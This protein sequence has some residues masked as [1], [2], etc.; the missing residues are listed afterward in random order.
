MFKGGKWIAETPEPTAGGVTDHGDLTGLKDDEHHEKYLLVDGSRTLT[1]DL[2]G[3]NKRITNLAKAVTDG[4]AVIFQQAIKD[5]DNAGGDLTGT[6]PSPTIN[7]LQGD[8]IQAN[9][10]KNTD[11]A[12]IWN[13]TA[14]TPQKQKTSQA[15]PFII[16]P[17]ATITR[18]KKQL[19][20]IWFN[21]DAPKNS[22]L[23][24]ELRALEVLGENDSADPFLTE[25]TINNIT[26]GPRNVFDVELK[27]EMR[28]MRFKF[29]LP[30]IEVTSPDMSLAKYAEKFA[31]KFMGYDK[32]KDKFATIFVQVPRGQIG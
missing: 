19:Y 3:G 15:N 30:K 5:G 10:P 29:N 14:W 12:L 20:E 21:I 28:F 9:L 32:E 2:D 7:L 13:G 31:I 23:I 17:L 6:Y 27:T 11:D 18:V 22:A 8:P 4:Q 1:G 16:L 24:K 25:I 26:S